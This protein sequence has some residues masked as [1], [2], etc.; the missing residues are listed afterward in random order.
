MR[1]R[2]ISMKM[3]SMYIISSWGEHLQE[4]EDGIGDGVEWLGGRWG[5]TLY[6]LSIVKFSCAGCIR[7][8]EGLPRCKR[9]GNSRISRMDC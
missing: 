9:D 6:F 3:M 5:V 1:E 2:E 8:R 7:R 4:S